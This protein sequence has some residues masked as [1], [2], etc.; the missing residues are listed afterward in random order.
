MTE[1]TVERDA[2][3]WSVVAWRDGARVEPRARLYGLACITA[4][5]LA[6]EL[7]RA[8]RLGRDDEREEVRRAIFS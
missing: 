5:V 4:Q 8:Y 7:D 3:G 6:A 2:V 1:W